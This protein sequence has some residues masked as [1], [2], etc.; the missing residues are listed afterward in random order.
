MARYVMFLRR[1]TSLGGALDGVGPENRDF[2]GPKKN[3]ENGIATKN[4]TST[5]VPIKKNIGL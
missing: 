4:C 3:L 2:F 5:T 1:A